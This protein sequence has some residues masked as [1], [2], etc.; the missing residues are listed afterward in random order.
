MMSNTEFHMKTIAVANRTRIRLSPLQRFV[1]GV[2]QLSIVCFAVT[3]AYGEGTT[4]PAGVSESRPAAR[5][6]V[7]VVEESEKLR[8]EVDRVRDVALATLA[9]LDSND[10]FNIYLPS[11]LRFLHIAM[12][13]P[14]RGGMRSAT[15]FLRTRLAVDSMRTPGSDLT[16]D[17]LDL[18]LQWKPTHVIVITAGDF[19]ELDGVSLKV[20]EVTKKQVR[21]T[22]LVVSEQSI[23]AEKALRRAVEDGGGELI[24]TRKR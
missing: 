17:R 23:E 2:S 16:L 19:R 11:S 14:D 10:L 21:V 20:G 3:F 13:P 15:K 8:P 12:F 6:L 9:S 22:L 24:L 5:R 1:L 18:T 7:V 4:R